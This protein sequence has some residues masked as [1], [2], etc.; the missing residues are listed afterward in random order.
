MVELW[1]TLKFL[2]RS[3]V[4]ELVSGLHHSAVSF[5]EQLQTEGFQVLNDVVFNQVLIGFDDDSLTP[6]IIEKIQASGECWVGGGA[7]QGRPVIRISVCSWATTEEDIA[8]S[9]RA[10]VAA[11][12]ALAA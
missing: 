2:G 4:D 12:A 9:V 7:W 8:R 1:A 10:F 6:Q 5:S 3:G 11:R